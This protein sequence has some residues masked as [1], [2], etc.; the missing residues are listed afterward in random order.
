[1]AQSHNVQ[2]FSSVRGTDG[3]TRILNY[4]DWRTCI[5]L[6]FL[7]VSFFFNII[8]L[9]SCTFYAFFFFFSFFYSLVALLGIKLHQPD[10]EC[11]PLLHQPS[12]LLQVLSFFLI[13]F[14]I[15]SSH[16]ILGLP[17]PLAPSSLVSHTCLGFLLSY[18]LI[19]CPN[20]PQFLL[21][22]TLVTGS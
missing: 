7:R 14:H 21:S 20:H 8:T 12:C 3:R 18:N 16:S 15:C 11:F 9:T 17:L 4:C 22:A 5:F 6:V 19:R 1:M 13:S 10:R 2:H